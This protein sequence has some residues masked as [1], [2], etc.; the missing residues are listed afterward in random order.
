MGNIVNYFEENYL[1][2]G[3]V[4]FVVVGLITIIN[5]KGIDLNTPTPAT[6]LVQSVTVETFNTQ[7][8]DTDEDMDKLSMLPAQGFCANYQGNSAELEPKCNELTETNCAEVGCC[9]YMA[10]GVNGKCVAG[11]RQGPTYKTDKDG[12]LITADTYYYL[13]KK[14]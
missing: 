7:I 9:V 10:N 4:I 11:S 2:I 8:G 5:I 3:I 14:Y 12:K 1:N 13:G 6:H